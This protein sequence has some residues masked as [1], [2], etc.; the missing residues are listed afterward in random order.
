HERHKATNETCQR[1][2]SE[3]EA[4][5]ALNER[6]YRPTGSDYESTQYPAA[7][8]TIVQGVSIPQR[9]PTLQCG[10]SLQFTGWRPEAAFQ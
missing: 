4:Q 8:G 6:A 2:N 5:E 7:R 10:F 9:S 3:H 1:G